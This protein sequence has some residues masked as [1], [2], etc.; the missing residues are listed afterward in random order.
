M[1]KQIS[2]Y[3]IGA[4]L[5][6]PANMHST[7]VDAL[8]REQLPQ[9]FSLA[10][11]LEDTVREE[12]VPQAEAELYQTLQALS[13]ASETKSFYLPPI[14]IRVRS[15]KQLQKLA[16][17]YRPFSRLLT[18]FILPKFYVDNSA[19]YIQT[20]QH[21]QAHIQ[22]DYFYMPI[23]E[24]PAMLELSHRYD[25]LARLREQLAEVAPQILNIRVGGND[26]SHAFG[27]R[28]H[29]HNTIYELRPVAAVLADIV[30]TFAPAYVVSGPV[31]EYYA[32]E[33]WEEGLRREL[34][35]DLLCGF[36]GKTIIHPSQIPVVNDCLRV[37]AAD[38]QDA[39]RI[40]SWNPA[41]PQLVSASADTTRMN[42]Y[43]THFRWAE[44]TLQ[45]ARIYGVREQQA[46]GHALYGS[47]RLLGKPRLRRF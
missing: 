11:C 32:G 33:G 43:N 38:Y 23:L 8:S 2:G 28:R 3:D 31:W 39:L 16:A 18:G 22:P 19:A 30:T 21:I 1:K 7:I 34:E 35:Q 42:E 29:V 26:L 14:F 47:I 44:K 46:P 12:A 4:L 40:A 10:F 41:S 5:Y 37:S 9:P 45:L 15:P 20:I 25:S 13:A 17:V 24:S 6:C 36:I 27:L